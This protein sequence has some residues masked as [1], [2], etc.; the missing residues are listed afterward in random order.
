MAK[1]ITGKSHSGVSKRT[2]QGGRKPKTSSMT[3]T[4]K[5]A[6]KRYRGQGR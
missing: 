4:Q 2:N 3:R 5:S 1:N 6:H